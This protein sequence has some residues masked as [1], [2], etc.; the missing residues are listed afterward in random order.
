MN[1]D[2]VLLR[3]RV[4]LKTEGLSDNWEKISEGL[5][6]ENSIQKLLSFH[7]GL[8]STNQKNALKKQ[9]F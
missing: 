2:R 1:N 9:T 4:N 5:W 8:V 7:Q 3:G 6:W